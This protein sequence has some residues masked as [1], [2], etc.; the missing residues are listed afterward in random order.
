MPVSS[1]APTTEDVPSA[2]GDKVVG[3]CDD[4]VDDSRS[5]LEDD[6][7]EEEEVVAGEDVGREAEDDG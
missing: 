7:E 6:L 1:V 2:E 4:P 3:A 5:T